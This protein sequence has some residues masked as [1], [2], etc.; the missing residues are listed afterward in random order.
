MGRLAMRYFL[1]LLPSQGLEGMC[2]RC[3]FFRS[4]VSA[5]VEEVCLRLVVDV[6]VDVDVLGAVTVLLVAAVDGF[7]AIV[8]SFLRTISV[9]FS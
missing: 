4:K 1:L 3:V 9:P 7:V 6:D 8:F 2:R 5:D